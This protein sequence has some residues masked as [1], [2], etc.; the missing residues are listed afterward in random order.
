[1]RRSTMSLRSIGLAA[2]LVVA[3]LLGG[4]RPAAAFESYIYGTA[5][6]ANTLQVLPDVC[7][8]LGP[9]LISCI[10][11]TDANGRYS[12]KFPDNDV[13][14]AEQ[15]LHFLYRA[16]GYQDYNSPHFVVRGA[17]FQP[18]PML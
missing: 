15:E 13:I 10:T 14:S 2:I 9:T 6:D 1:M 3:G 4:S 16:Q 18:A 8:V 12:I 5:Y 11:H 17:T 7:V